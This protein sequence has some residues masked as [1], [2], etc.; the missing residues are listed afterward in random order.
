MK[1]AKILPADL[2]EVAR[3]QH[4]LCVQRILMAFVVGPL[5]AP[6]LGLTTAAVWLAVMVGSE[7]WHWFATRSAHRGSM[8]A[9]EMN[10]YLL[11]GGLA[12]QCWTML[13]VLYW[14][15]PAPGAG[16]VAIALWA[17]QLIY[18]Q[19][20]VFQS[21]VTIVVGNASTVLAMLLLPIMIPR[22]NPELQAPLTVAGLIGVA[23]AISG[24]MR[25]LGII[26]SLA[27]EKAAVEHGATHDALTGLLNRT[28]M[29]RRLSET[30]AEGQPCAFFFLDLDRFKQVNDTM[31][32]QS[33]DA[34]LQ[35]FAR[36]LR[37][38]APPKAHIAR[39]G[40][41]E[42]AIVISASPGGDEVEVLCHE[43]LHMVT[44]PF[45][46]PRGQAHVGASIGVVFAPDEGSDP[47]EL[48]RKADIALYAAKAGGRGKFRIF[49]PDM[50]GAVRDR[51]NLED[52]LREV[53]ARG[54][55][56]Q[57]HYQP[58]VRADE[59]CCA[60]EALLRWAHPRLGDVAPARLLAVAEETGLIIPLGEW[61]LDE[62]VQFAARWPELSVAINISP[63][64]LKE[65]GFAA[66]VAELAARYNVE[67]SRIELEVTE[68][69]FLEE[70][71]AVSQ[72]LKALRD[73]GFRI[74]L[75]DFGT[76][77]SSLRHLHHF[78]VDRVK[79][80]QS[81]L[82]D[83][84]DSSEAAAIIQSV[85]QLAHAMGL[86][87]TAEGVE[88][89]QHKEFLIRAGIDEMQGFYFSHACRESEL[90]IVLEDKSNMRA[91][92]I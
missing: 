83:V 73:T 6:A 90:G 22:L 92:A 26:T 72:A 27:R 1:F 48:M 24:A 60:V 13:G 42:F 91:S 78:S 5:S 45:S 53:L 28:L 55:G 61:V 36:R 46:V 86:Q 33:G 8:T 12:V 71:T 10:T 31:G 89:L 76:G 7:T 44:E 69:V 54:N 58:K 35:Q 85:I 19:R 59:E 41:D 25:T 79:L 84:E 14:L 21:V 38:I 56:L 47:D 82:R 74:A 51:T 9:W 64:Q 34:L 4:R 11:A 3:I 16:A 68:K 88:T 80:D 43:I 2:V 37:D 20:F 50:D 52:D 40:G 15:N 57:L 81:Y 39:F 17:A 18:T 29:Q 62:G 67:P 49:H 75:D 23:F 63:A 66:W 87:V 77:Y 70:S 32:H 30:L 65:A